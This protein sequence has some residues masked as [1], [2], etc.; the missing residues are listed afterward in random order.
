MAQSSWKS[1]G[2]KARQTIENIVNPFMD[3]DRNVHVMPI[4]RIQNINL[5]VNFVDTI[6]N[7]MCIVEHKYED[8]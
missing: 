3:F 6:H 8:L 5:F 2:M 1:Q 4:L 7:L